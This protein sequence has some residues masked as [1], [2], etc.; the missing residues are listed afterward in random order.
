[1][2]SGSEN[3]IVQPVNAQRKVLWKAGHSTA[4]ECISDTPHSHSLT[5]AL[6]RPLP[7]ALRTCFVF[8][9]VSVNPFVV[10]FMFRRMFNPPLTNVQYAASDTTSV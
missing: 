2:A 7:L 5:H 6:T 8:V 9:L 3:A 10:V 4:A 1:M